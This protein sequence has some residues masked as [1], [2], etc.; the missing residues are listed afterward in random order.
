MALGALK[1]QR[2]R[3]DVLATQNTF[4]WVGELAAVDSRLL[5]TPAGDVRQGPDGLAGISLVAL[6]GSAG[7][8][9][10]RR[11][12]AARNRAAP[13][14]RAAASIDVRSSVRAAARDVDL[15]RT[16]AHQAP[17]SSPRVSARAR[18][19]PAMQAGG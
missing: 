4:C 7:S 18:T 9:V 17:G 19:V 8:R 10:R 11:R 6:E 14:D 3:I 13:R 1:A 16:R 15:S 2:E 5:K 12:H